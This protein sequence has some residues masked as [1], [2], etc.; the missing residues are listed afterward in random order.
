VFRCLGVKFYPRPC[1][2][3]HVTTSMQLQGSS[4]QVG[5]TAYLSSHVREFWTDCPKLL[6]LQFCM[7]FFFYIFTYSSG[8]DI[9]YARDAVA[10]ARGFPPF[11]LSFCPLARQH[12]K[13]VGGRGSQRRR[14]EEAQK[15]RRRRTSITN[16]NPTR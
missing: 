15:R 5:D 16:L 14:Y 6:F 9:T 8:G 1:L 12:R 10:H 3:S 2:S 7:S 4:L 11:P 13:M